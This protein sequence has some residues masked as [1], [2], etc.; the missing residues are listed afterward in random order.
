ME[1]NPPTGQKEPRHFLTELYIWTIIL[2]GVLVITYVLFQTDAAVF[3]LRFLFLLLLT[4]VFGPFLSV[5]IPKTG[6]SISVSETFIF[7]ALFIYGDKPACLLA[8]A[9]SLLGSKRIGVTRPAIFLF[10]ASISTCSIFTTGWVLSLIFGHYPVVYT[11][12]L[13]ATAIAVVC[14]AAL[15]Q[16]IASS[17]LAAVAVALRTNQP[18]WP[19]W[20]QNF[21]VTSLNSFAGAFTAAMVAALTYFVGL[22]ALLVTLPIVVI[23]YFAYKTYQK[24]VEVSLAQVEQ[25]ERHVK[26]LSHY[27][28]EQERIRD[29]F[30]QMEKMSALGELASG[31]AHN[32]NNALTAILARSHLI[33]TQTSDP[34]IRRNIELLV[35]SADDAATTVRRIQDFARRDSDETQE[36]V[37]VCELLGDVAEITKPRWQNSAQAHNVHIT[38]EIDCEGTYVMGNA[39]QLREVLI[40]IIFNSV[41]AMPEGGALRLTSKLLHSSVAISVADTG[42]GMYPEVCQRVFEPFFTTKGRLGIGLGLAV[43][44][45]IIRRLGGTIEIDSAFGKGTNVRIILPAADPSNLPQTN[46]VKKTITYQAVPPINI[47]YRTIFEVTG[48]PKVISVRA[49]RSTPLTQT[50]HSNVRVL[51]VDDEPRVMTA[52]RDLLIGHGYDV[53]AA[54]SGIEAIEI[55][56]SFCPA[57]VLADN[58]MSPL[59]GLQTIEELRNISPDTLS[60]LITG[61]ADIGIVMNALRQSVFDFLLKPVSLEHLIDSIER[62]VKHLEARER[63]RRQHD[64]LS[65]VSHELRA[66]LQAPLRYLENILSE[67]NHLNEKQRTILQRTAKGIKSEVRLINNLLDLQYLESGRFSIKLQT[68]SLRDA[69]HEVVESFSIQ[70]LDKGVSIIWHPPSYSFLTEIDAEQIVQAIS[71]ILNNALQHTP[72]GGKITLRLFRGLHELRLVI[73]DEGPGIAEPYQERIFEKSFQVPTPTGKKGLGIGLYIANE[74][75]RAHH[76]K[77]V[78]KSKLSRGSMFVL[79]FPSTRSG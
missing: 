68:H 19:T 61:D 8:A 60:I 52:Y 57:I 17:S 54:G 6:G 76:G 13:T 42:T 1:S 4:V 28:T 79:C 50:S 26:E 71:N 69:V 37:N 32:F 63:E 56:R 16:F 62:A 18:I 48:E 9:D 78:L 39:S 74:I 44:Y 15:T 7:V 38:L 46:R 45:G 67:E 24:N 2:L 21:L 31:V 65:I 58:N 75:M 55:A 73:R 59:S 53:R 20:R 72:S 10:N 64:F 70:A 49:P 41:D 36:L 11:Y 33:L 43:S 34:L 35:Q 23:I 51:V 22:Y 14:T 27:I 25:A 66:P 40:N 12:P 5:S 47:E 30:T 3:D 77:I 29:Q